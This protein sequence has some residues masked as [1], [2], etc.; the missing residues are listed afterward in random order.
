M[1]T[2]FLAL[3]ILGSAIST[4]Q[5]QISQEWVARYASPTPYSDVPYAMTVDGDGHVY[6]TG[7]TATTGADD[8]TTIKYNSAGDK[9]WLRNLD[10]GGSDAAVARKAGGGSTVDGDRRR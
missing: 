7:A 9:E 10:G 1:K 2:L 4:A 6:V 5:A 8:W 3:L